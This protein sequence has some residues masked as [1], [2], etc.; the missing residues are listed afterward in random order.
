MAIPPRRLGPAIHTRW[1]CAKWSAK[2]AAG[3]FLARGALTR[4]YDYYAGSTAAP[5]YAIIFRP[6]DDCAQVIPTYDCHSMSARCRL[7]APLRASV[8]IT[9]RERERQREGW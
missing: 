2:Y 3:G 7:F 5:P 4:F 1:P 6:M 8:C 9:E